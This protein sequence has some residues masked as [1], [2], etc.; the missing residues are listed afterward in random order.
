MYDTGQVVSQS[1]FQSW[2]QQQQSANSESQKTLPSYAPVYFPAPTV[3][4]S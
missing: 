4:G 2:I 1:D 3:K